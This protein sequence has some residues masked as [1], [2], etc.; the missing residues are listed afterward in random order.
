MQTLTVFDS[1]MCCSSGIFGS[2]VDQVL[3]LMCCL[4]GRG[5]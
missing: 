3:L 2:D 5:L 1:E 4:K